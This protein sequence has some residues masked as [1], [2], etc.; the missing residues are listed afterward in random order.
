MDFL[1]KIN[2]AA[3]KNLLVTYV[4]NSSTFQIYGG[5]IDA[6]SYTEYDDSIELHTEDGKESILL[7]KNVEYSKKQLDE[8][9]TMYVFNELGII[10]SQ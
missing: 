10:I 1:K 9:S 3:E 5:V 2:E 8:F 7:L 4:V 6:N